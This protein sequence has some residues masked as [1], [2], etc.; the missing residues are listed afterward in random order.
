MKLATGAG[1][2]GFPSI[3]G[4]QRAVHELAQRFGVGRV[5]Q[6]HHIH[7][8]EIRRFAAVFREL[9]GVE[10]RQRGGE[11]DRNQLALRRLGA[12]LAAGEVV[13]VAEAGTA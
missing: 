9:I 13:G 11:Q 7:Q 4:G 8:L 1:E 12:S 2:L 3:R 5:Q 6:V 10:P